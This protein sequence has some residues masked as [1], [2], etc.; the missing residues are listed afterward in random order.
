MKDDFERTTAS[1]QMILDDFEAIM[2]YQTAMLKKPKQERFCEVFVA[3][4]GLGGAAY[5]QTINPDSTDLNAQKRASDFLKKPEISG[6]IKQLS[7][8]VRNRAMNDLVAYRLKALNFDPAKYTGKGGAIRI[9]DVPVADRI[10]I[11]LEAK[12][13]D[14]CL[15]YLPVFPSPERSA[16]AL[17]KIMGMDKSKMELTGTDGGPIEVRGIDVSFVT[18]EE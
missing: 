1:G 2:G 9:E 13:I 10:G 3:N 15:Y 18:P 11:G 17:Q 6:R 14:G 8:L 5:K 4:G 12:M 16:D 7:S